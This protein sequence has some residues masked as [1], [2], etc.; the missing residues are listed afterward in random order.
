VRKDHFRI[1]CFN[2]DLQVRINRSIWESN[3]TCK[4]Q[5]YTSKI[6][7]NSPKVEESIH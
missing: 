2:F 7:F 6:N 5:F 3:Q 4:N 1:K